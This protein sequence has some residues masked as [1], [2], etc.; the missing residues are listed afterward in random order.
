MPRTLYLD[1]GSEYNFAAF[2]KPA[3]LLLNPENGRPLI[4]AKPYNA[5][6]KP[7]ESIFRLLEHSFFSMIPEWIGGNRQRKKTA[8]VGRAPVP[9]STFG[10]FIATVKACTDLY[11]NTPQSTLGNRSPFEC[12]DAFVRGG[13]NMTTAS[14]DAF[15]LAFTT[16]QVRDVRKGCIQFDG[17][18]WTC[19]ELQKYQS[20]RI[21][22]L[23]PQYE[24]WNR[25]AAQRR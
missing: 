17:S 8:N 22:V 9:I 4:H 23:V 25:F 18:L 3:L 7:I 14:I 10:R 19:R 5:A 2:L 12:Y 13:W 15:R 11:H 6:A 1:N 16:E 20:Q 24:R 21:V